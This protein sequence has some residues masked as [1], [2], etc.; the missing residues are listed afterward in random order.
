MSLSYSSG[1]YTLTLPQNTTM[2]VYGRNY[3]GG[4]TASVQLTQ[5]AVGGKFVEIVN[6]AF[7]FNYGSVLTTLLAN[8]M[9]SSV[10]PNLT[11]LTG[12]FNVTAYISSVTMDENYFTASQSFSVTNY[13]SESAMTGSKITGKVTLQ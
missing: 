8:G 4:T 11:T 9:T 1:T 7:S 6:N 10:F 2:Y 12:Q 3:N 5:D 13:S